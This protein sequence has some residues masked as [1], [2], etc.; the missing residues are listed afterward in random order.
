MAV[1]KTLSLVLPTAAVAVE[2]TRQGQ[3]DA[4]Q[5]YIRNP[6]LDP[7]T[8]S[9]CNSLDNYQIGMALGV[10]GSIGGIAWAVKNGA[11]ILARSNKGESVVQAKAFS[12][13]PMAVGLTGAI[14]LIATTGFL[15]GVNHFNAHYYHKCMILNPNYSDRAAAVESRTD[16]DAK[17]IFDKFAPIAAWFA[18]G[19]VF[20]TGIGS[21]AAEGAA[22]AGEVT[23]ATAATA[24]ALGL[25]APFVVSLRSFVELHDTSSNIL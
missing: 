23:F 7:V 13:D 3:M 25:L 4:S 6:S 8:A 10:L 20:A 17:G 15:N 22:S 24:G 2:L 12:D 21:V 18:A 5:R 19:S 14:S 1:P 9:E 11:S 16:V